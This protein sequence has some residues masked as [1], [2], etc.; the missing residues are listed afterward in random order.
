MSLIYLG[1]RTDH[2]GAGSLRP[3]PRPGP[4]SPPHLRLLTPSSTHPQSSSGSGRFRM[5]VYYSNLL[6]PCPCPWRRKYCS[7]EI[8]PWR[9]YANMPSRRPL[10]KGK[11]A[12]TECR[13]QKVVALR[14]MDQNSVSPSDIFQAK[15]DVYLDP[16]QPCTRCR[17]VKAACIIS[18]P[19]K[20]EHKRKY[21]SSAQPAKGEH[22]GWK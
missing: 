2:A 22:H 14:F 15:C 8:F 16:D 13:Q 12:C 5:S 9:G 10:K 17:K 1:T 20:R 4:A 6:V 19:F 7:H 11:K 18:D 3:S 21:V